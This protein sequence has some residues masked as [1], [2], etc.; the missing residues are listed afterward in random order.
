MLTQ[1]FYSRVKLKFTGL[2]ASFSCIN[3]L[4]STQTARIN[5][6]LINLFIMIGDVLL[7]FLWV[8]GKRG[9]G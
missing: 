7:I 1:D 8:S 9:S 6:S 3:L 2:N 4:G 5:Y